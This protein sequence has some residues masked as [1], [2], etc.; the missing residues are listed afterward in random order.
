MAAEPVTKAQRRALLAV[1]RPFA[2]QIDK[3]EIVGSRARGTHRPGSD[4]DL[5]IHGDVDAATLARLSTD[6]DESDLS[7]SADLHLA[8]AP[9][10]EALRPFFAADARPLFD[11]GD[12]R[13]KG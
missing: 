8:G 2:A 6:L 1:F 9:E 4:I 12:L 10:D 13:A 11:G 7:I 5:L 3:V